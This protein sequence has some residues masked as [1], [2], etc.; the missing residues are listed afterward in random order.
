M[1]HNKNQYNLSVTFTKI[2]CILDVKYLALEGLHLKFI[3][4]S[5]P[6]DALFSLNIEIKE[7]IP[8]AAVCLECK[9]GFLGP[10]CPRL[11]YSLVLHVLYL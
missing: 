4:I 6:L 3:S 5:L 2:C 8:E 10:L 9:E 1:I 11:S 7:F